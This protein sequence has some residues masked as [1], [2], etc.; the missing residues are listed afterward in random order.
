MED[1]LW[2]SCA[3]TLCPR[4]LQEGGSKGNSGA[5]AGNGREQEKTAELT[6]Q[7]HEKLAC[8]VLSMI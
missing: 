8:S 4:S 2:W 1:G 3:S 7:V 6:H 5:G